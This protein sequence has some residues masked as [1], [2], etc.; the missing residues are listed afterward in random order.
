MNPRACELRRRDNK[1]CPIKDALYDQ[2]YGF[3][4]A[5]L[6]KRDEIV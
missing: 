2:R 1:E 4:G 5:I 6:E 3:M